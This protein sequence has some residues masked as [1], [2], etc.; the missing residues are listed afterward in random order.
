[1][2]R[3][4]AHN[5]VQLPHR[6]DA[7]VLVEILKEVGDKDSMAILRSLARASDEQDFKRWIGKAVQAIKTRMT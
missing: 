4:T 1:M 2:L 5:L 7:P 6:S 3:L